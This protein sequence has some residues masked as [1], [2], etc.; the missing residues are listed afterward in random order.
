M[1]IEVSVLSFD[2]GL[3]FHTNYFQVAYV[4]PL[5]S[6]RSESILFTKLSLKVL[7]FLIETTIFPMFYYCKKINTRLDPKDSGVIHV[8]NFELRKRTSVIR[9]E[10]V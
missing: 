6:I 10:V 2:S 9:S 5:R 4:Y 7:D 8:K 3:G 1:E